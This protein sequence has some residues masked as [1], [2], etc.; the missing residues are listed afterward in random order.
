MS[1]ELCYTGSIRRRL[2]LHVTKDG[3]SM[4]AKNHKV[5]QSEID[6]VSYRRVPTWQIAVGQR[7]GLLC[8]VALIGCIHSLPQPADAPP[9]AIKV[10]TQ[11]LYFGLPILDWIRTLIAMKGCHLDQEEMVQ[12]QKRIAEKKPHFQRRNKNQR[13]RI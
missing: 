12:I 13:R 11:G 4:M 7:H 3:G 9:A 6:G 8:S 2:R 1:K 5:S 10:L